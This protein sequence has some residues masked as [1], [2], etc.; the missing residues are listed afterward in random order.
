MERK[1]MLWRVEDLI[2]DVDDKYYVWVP[3]FVEE[4]TF[5]MLEIMWK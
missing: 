3:E 5:S 2:S 1:S 4:P